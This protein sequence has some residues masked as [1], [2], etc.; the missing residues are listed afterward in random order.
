[1][2][3]EVNVYVVGDGDGVVA[4]RLINILLVQKKKKTFVDR[5]TISLWHFWQ[6][7]Q[8]N[9]QRQEKEKRTVIWILKK[10]N[11]QE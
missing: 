5:E 3:T 8:Y 7:P 11:E 1:M 10:P 4:T 2:S 9:E 6:K